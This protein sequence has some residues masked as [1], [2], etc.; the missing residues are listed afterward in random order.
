MATWCV[1]AVVLLL[2]TVMSRSCL[3]NSGGECTCDF[4][5]LKVSCTRVNEDIGVLLTK[6]IPSET[7]VLIMKKNWVDEAIS[8]KL[9]Y[10]SK[11]QKL[12][13]VDFSKNRIT[14]IDSYTFR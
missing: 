8:L 3:L 2:I 4:M 6:K 14:R 13:V 7:K 1:R 11:L 5:Q 10:F 9:E 12:Q